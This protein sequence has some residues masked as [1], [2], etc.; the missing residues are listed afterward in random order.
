[1]QVV[2]PLQDLNNDREMGRMKEKTSVMVGGG[3][4]IDFHYLL[5]PHPHK[6]KM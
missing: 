6:H 2:N 5:I 3:S 4:H 1:M